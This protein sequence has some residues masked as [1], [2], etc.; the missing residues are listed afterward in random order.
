MNYSYV[1]AVDN[2]NELKENG[3]NVQKVD[4]DYIVSFSDDKIDFYENLHYISELELEKS[5]DVLL[6]FLSSGIDDSS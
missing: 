2:A 3:F 5:R 4:G 6:D 1:M